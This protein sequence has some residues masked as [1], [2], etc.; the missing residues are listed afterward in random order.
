L[1]VIG[2]TAAFDKRMEILAEILGFLIIELIFS[3]IGWVCLYVWYRN[4]RKMEEIKNKEYAGEYSSV[5]RVMML[6]LIAGAGA[7]FMFGSVIFF[8]GLWIYQAITN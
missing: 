4:R 6:N 8:L 1:D 3:G 5:G 2:C 7:I